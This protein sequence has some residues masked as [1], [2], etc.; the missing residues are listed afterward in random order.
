MRSAQATPLT[1]N[2]TR[3]HA[4]TGHQRWWC[5]RIAAWAHESDQSRR[6]GARVASALSD[7]VGPG[8]IAEC[9]Q[10]MGTVT[11]TD[12]VDIFDKD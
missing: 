4:V 6:C 8:A 2:L 7:R 11:T 10:A 3:A 5:N 12:G 1:R 9:R